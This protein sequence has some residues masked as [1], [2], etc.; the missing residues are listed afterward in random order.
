MTLAGIL[1]EIRKKFRQRPRGTV[2]TMF[3]LTA[4]ALFL[5]A[6]AIN[7]TNVS[8]V[9]LEVDNSVVEE[10]ELFAVDIYAFAH[11]PVNAVDVTLRFDKKAV[12]VVSVDRG[13]SVLTI[14]TEDPII[15]DDRVTLRGGTFRKGFL[16]EH[17]IATVELRA[18]ES[19]QG[20]FKTENVLLLA[21]DGHGTPVT[22][23]ESNQSTVEF[24]VYDEN[25]DPK[26][27]HVNVAVS[28]LTDVDK[29]GEVT[30]QDISSFMSA[31]VSKQT[32][33][34]FNGDGRMS[35]HDFSIILSDFFLG[36]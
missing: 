31:W 27:I 4:L 15:Q 2:R 33:Y 26:N 24:F 36:A 19:G 9:K 34:D 18:R 20:Q 6:A 17:M 35:L 16:G 10:G 3:S 1:R 5:T 13:Q 7:S 23:A 30:L 21:G 8:Y 12:E 32:V 11:V 28:I 14:W 29:D 22:V 25:V